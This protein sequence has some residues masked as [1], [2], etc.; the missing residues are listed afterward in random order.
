MNEAIVVFS[1]WRQFKVKE[2]AVRGY[3][4]ML[5]QFCLFLRNPPI[6]DIKIFDIITYFGMMRDLGWKG[7]SFI[8]RAVAIRKFF[9]FFR[10]QGMNVI[11]E[12]LIPVPDQEHSLPRVLDNEMFEKLVAVIPKD[13]N[14]PRHVRNLALILML[15][16]TG[17]RIG[18]I[19]SLE[20]KELDLVRRRAVIRTEK[21]KGSRPFREIFWREETNAAITKWLTR[22]QILLRGK[23]VEA[24]FVCCA[25]VRVAKP[26]TIGGFGEVLRRYSHKAN[27]PVIVNAHS[28]RHR[29]GHEI[30]KNGGSGADVMNILGHA[31]LASS[32]VY[33]MMFDQELEGRHRKLLGA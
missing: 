18:E 25:G 12:E 8:P 2:S 28:F 6:E 31:S 27:L 22:R 5:K 24:L 17:G 23:N 19:L 13:T 1:Q 26:I 14:D 15:H 29:V 33:T 21:N 7:N 32:T 11:H 20:V 9:E 16:D 3:E 30:I 4:L 10:L